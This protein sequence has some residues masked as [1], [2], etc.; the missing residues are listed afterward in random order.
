MTSIDEFF[1]NFLKVEDIKEETTV[2]VKEVKVETIGREED[3]KE[4]PVVYFNEFEKGL[5][6]NKINSEAL[7][8]I[9]DSREIEDWPE[10]QVVLYVDKNVM[11][12]GKRVGGVRIKAVE[13][14]KQVH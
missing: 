13:V 8:E 9:A 12:G 7:A 14:S 2:T 1:G 4:K 11:F 5:A 10:K 6:L 3:A